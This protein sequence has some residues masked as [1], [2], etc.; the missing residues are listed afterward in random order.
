MRFFIFY[1]NICC[2]LLDFVLIGVC[3]VRGVKRLSFESQRFCYLE[4]VFFVALF[5]LGC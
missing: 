3:H 5:V 1:W 2:Q 4:N